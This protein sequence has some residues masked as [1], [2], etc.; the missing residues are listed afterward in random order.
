M[1]LRRRKAET[2]APE[3]DVPET[4][5][6]R[7][8]GRPRRLSA[9]RK[10]CVFK[11]CGRLESSYRLISFEWC[12]LVQRCVSLVDDIGRVFGCG[13]VVGR[14]CMVGVWWKREWQKERNLSGDRVLMIGSL[15]PVCL[16]IHYELH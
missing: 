14:V 3:T 11:D 10:V 12:V 1:S 13:W 7:D 15:Y 2:E 6:G 9:R 4:E 8:G 5:E 16:R